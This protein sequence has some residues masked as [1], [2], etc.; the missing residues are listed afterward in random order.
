MRP[1][2]IDAAMLRQFVERKLASGLKPT[3]VGHCVRLLSTFFADVVEQGH[4]TANPCAS[5]PRSTRRLYRSNYDVTST[6]F[7]QSLADVRRVYLALP[8]SINVAFAVGAFAGLRT[9]EVLGLSWP[10]IDFAT[11]R[12]HIRR[13]AREGRLTCVK[14]DEGRVAPLQDALAPILTAHK[15]RTGG[16][17]LVFEPAVP[18]RGGSADYPARFMRAQTLAKAFAGSPGSVRPA[19][20]ELVRSNAAQLRKLVGAGWRFD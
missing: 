3:T 15:L 18:G 14:D 17:G 4:V 9:A 6:P 11:R 20:L 5:L 19:V 12:I 16:E 7:L 10:D 13:Q 8:S 1:S 2:E